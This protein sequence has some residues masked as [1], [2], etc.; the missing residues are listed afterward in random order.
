MP[1][2]TA[3]GRGTIAGLVVTTCIL[4]AC[5]SPTSPK[6]STGPSSSASTTTTGQPTVYYANVAGDT[7]TLTLFS[8]PLVQPGQVP[9]PIAQAC[10]ANDDAANAA[11]LNRTLFREVDEALTLTSKRPVE[12]SVQFGR[13]SFGNSGFAQTFVQVA[14]D[15]TA[16]CSASPFTWNVVSPRHA[17][18]F[19]IWIIYPNV[20]TPSQP[21]GDQAEIAAAAWRMPTVS[22]A[23]AKATV[24]SVSGPG[25]TEAL[26][27]PAGQV[28]SSRR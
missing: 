24:A 2:V 21:G 6:A 5:S 28:V 20:L 13:S 1:A 10:L 23:N 12:A 14:S 4:A 18:H 15:G 25:L 3:P 8:Q 27:F 26:F 19:T 9:N 11:L 7:A 16:T 22:L 17:V